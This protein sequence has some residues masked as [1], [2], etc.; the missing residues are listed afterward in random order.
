MVCVIIHP[1]SHP[2]FLSQSFPKVE[3]NAQPM[4]SGLWKGIHPAF[5]VL[6]N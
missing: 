5:W 4:Q 6:K 1:P 2:A 3:L